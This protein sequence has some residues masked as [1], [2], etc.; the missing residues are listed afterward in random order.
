MIN[1]GST[2]RLNALGI[3]QEQLAAR[4]AVT[5]GS[6][7]Q[8]LTKQNT[9]YIALLDALEIMSEEQRRAWLKEEVK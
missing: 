1:A 2:A 3:T 4:L 6:V 9:R 7:V 8:A 5:R